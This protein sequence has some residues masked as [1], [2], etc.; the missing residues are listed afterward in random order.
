MLIRPRR[1]LKQLSQRTGRNWFRG[2]SL[3]LV[4]GGEDHGEIA[5]PSN[6]PH[7]DDDGMGRDFMAAGIRRTGPYIQ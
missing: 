3:I 6:T 7:E 5:G 2:P 4:R 1:L